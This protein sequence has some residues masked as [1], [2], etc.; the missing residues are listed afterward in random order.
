[1]QSEKP[2][3]T[4]YFGDIENNFDLEPQY[5][6][7]KPKI[8]WQLNKIFNAKK[9]VI[10]TLFPISVFYDNIKDFVEN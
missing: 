10:Y 7:A 8:S 4:K 5:Y 2:K 3:F 1:M 6:V 9:T